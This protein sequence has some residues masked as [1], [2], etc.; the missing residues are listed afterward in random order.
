VEGLLQAGCH[1]TERKDIESIMEKRNDCENPLCELLPSMTPGGTWAKVL[2]W[3]ARWHKG[4]TLGYKR[5][6]RGSTE[7]S[8][9]VWYKW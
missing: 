6:L 3:I 7:K 5:R 8:E 1:W 2:L 9:L 4:M